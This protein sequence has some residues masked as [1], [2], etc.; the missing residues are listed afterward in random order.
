M[1]EKDRQIVMILQKNARTSNAEIARRL[2]MAP[3]AVYERIRKLE[4]RGIIC[5]YEARL[6]SKALG[7]GLV[8]YVFVRTRE[9]VGKL[10]TGARLAELPEVQEVHQIAGEDCYLVKVRAADTEALGR[11]M[12]KRFGSIPSVRSTRTTIVLTTLKESALLPVDGA[13]GGD[14]D[15]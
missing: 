13:R 12:R 11:L 14:G 8:A 15:E 2:G 9:P 1:D 5:G 3:S 10:E 4:A 7:L 6:S